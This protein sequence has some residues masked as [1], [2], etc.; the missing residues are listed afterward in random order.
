MLQESLLG[1]DMLSTSQSE[2][3]MTLTIEVRLYYVI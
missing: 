1:N 3:Q 2:Q